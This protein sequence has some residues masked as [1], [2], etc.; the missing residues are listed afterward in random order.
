M[1]S[2]IEIYKISE[3]PVFPKCL[4]YLLAFYYDGVERGASGEDKG[5][6]IKT[7]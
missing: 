4:K 7:A 3:M 1:S 5:A 6:V 2:L